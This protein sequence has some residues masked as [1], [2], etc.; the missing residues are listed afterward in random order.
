VEKC[1]N[2]YEEVKIRAI[3]ENGHSVEYRLKR[4]SK[5]SLYDQLLELME[6]K[7]F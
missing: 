6:T 7:I 1:R 4:D 2:G 3:E 5:K